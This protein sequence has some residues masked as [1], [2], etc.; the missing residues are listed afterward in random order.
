MDVIVNADD[1][2]ISRQVNDAI[3]EMVSR[4]RVT[5][6]TIIGNGPHVEEACRNIDRFP[7]CSFGAHLNV[8]QFRPLSGPAKLGRLLDDNGEFDSDKIRQVDIDSGLAE[9][10][11][12]EFSSQIENLRRLGVDVSHLDS[13]NYVLS[14]PKMFFVLKK[15]QRRFGIRKVRI[16]R[17]IY[18]DGLQEHDGLTAFKLALDPEGSGDDI[19]RTKRLKKVLYNFMLRHYYRT[20]TTQG[21]SGFRLFYEYAR[22]KK[23]NFRS[24]EV[25]VHPGS[26]YYDAGEIE[27]LK[28]PWEEE[29]G[30]PIRLISY[31]DLA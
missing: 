2:G 4:G 20:K 8:T 29:L 16:S 25:V 26:D 13:H 6:V 24:F 9:G 28:G 27:I 17:N 10:I 19:K 7:R 22:W 21:F 1:L 23:M 30:F 15:L 3:F 5:S 18:G 12:E 31:H 14:I 11:L